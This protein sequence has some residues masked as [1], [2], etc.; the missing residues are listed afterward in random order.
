MFVILTEVIAFPAGGI[1]G[2]II[3]SM[4]VVMVI[5][6]IACVVT[7]YENRLPVIAI[8][9]EDP[10]R[11]LLTLEAGGAEGMVQQSG[12]GGTGGNWTFTLK[13]YFVRIMQCCGFQ[14]YDRM[15]L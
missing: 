6:K 11:T 8:D 13:R 15:F 10:K 2:I 12:G 5:V 1:A 7:G 4:V 14:N 3:I 9:P